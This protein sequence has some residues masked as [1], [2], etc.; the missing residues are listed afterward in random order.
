MI[1]KTAFIDWLKSSFQGTN[2]TASGRRITAFWFVVL[3]T[4]TCFS[5]IVLAYL[6][7]L[8]EHKIDQIDIETLKVLTDLFIYITITVLTLFGIVTVQQIT[9]FFQFKKSDKDVKNEQQPPQ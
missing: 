1:G 2:G 3:A 9:S 8:L 4:I 5:I 6:M 7:I